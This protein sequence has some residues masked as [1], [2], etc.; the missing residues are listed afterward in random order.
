ML[1]VVLVPL[2]AALGFAGLRIDDALAHADE[3][4][5]V[6]R[7]AGTSRTGSSL[8]QALVDERDLAVDPKAKDRPGLTDKSGRATTDR[9]AEEFLKQLS[10]LPSGTNMERQ[11]TVTGAALD[12]LAKLRALSD[13]GG[14]RAEVE[15]GYGGIVVSVASLYNQ[16][17]GI[18]ESA[19]AAGWTLYTIALDNVMLTSQRSVLSDAASTT[20][21][22]LTPGQQGNL[23]ASQLVRDIVAMEFGLYA[24]QDEVE[25]YRNITGNERARKV[26]Q[27]IQSLGGSNTQVALDKVLP[28]T[29]YQ[30]FTDMST[31]LSELRANVENRIVA[32]ASEQKR[33]ARQQVVTDA[34]LAGAVLLVAALLAFMTSRHLVHGLRALRRA[35]VTVARDHLPEVTARLSRGEPL[36]TALEGKVVGVRTRDEIGDVAR[37]FNQV[38]LEAV[39][40]ARRQVALRDDV[41]LLFQNLSRRNQALVQRQLAL[42]TELEHSEREPEEL[43][44]LFHLDHLATRIRRNSEN[45]LVLAGAEVSAERRETTALLAVVRTA[46][47]EI[48]EYQRV[49]YRELPDTGVVGYA[50]DDLVHLVAELLDNAA[51]F[52]GPDTW[53]QVSGR[54]LPDGRVLLEIRD[55]GIGMTED[56]LADAAEVL[57]QTD[58]NRVDLSRTLGLYVVGALARKHGVT[59]R[60][61]PNE[62]VG[63]SVALVLPPE[64]LGTPTGSDTPPAAPSA[65]RPAAPAASTASAA[66]AAPMAPMAP[67]AQPAPEPVTEPVPVARRTAQSAPE[68]APEAPSAPGRT[69]P[70]PRTDAGLPLRTRRARAGTLD[71]NGPA[72]PPVPTAG[73]ITHPD[74]AEMRRRM[75]V[76]SQGIADADTQDRGTH[77]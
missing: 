21:G 49:A 72:V 22:R 76:L 31:H 50:A 62:P 24:T 42:I 64:I 46:A 77:G 66:P 15:H 6:E 5:T 74:P 35:A 75:R 41:N 2:M 58:G 51:S 28:A 67:A 53:V 11:R 1:I 19:R 3:Y 14:S 47:S 45:L 30:D 4:S 37:A 23:L 65:A 48:E 71:G 36:P 43:T 27:A 61:H 73:T 8:I 16:V 69:T 29:W 34:L 18:G 13:S 40:L 12:N 7:I 70:D 56:G 9:W 52:S 38:Y 26:V 25:A 55:Q 20:Q 68:P 44:R 63:L 60:L 33:Q 32:A 17:G 39:R 10:E 54:L 59:V 57:A